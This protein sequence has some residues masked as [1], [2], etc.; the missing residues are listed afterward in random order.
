MTESDRRPK[1]LFLITKSNFGGAQRYVF[2]MARAMQEEYDVVV[3]FGGQGALKE[4]LEAAGIR[5]VEITGFQ[6]DVNPLKELRSWRELYRLYKTEQP[7]IV[8]L[9]SS[10]AGLSGALIGRIAGVRPI[11]FT[12]H[13]WPFLEPRAW[14]WRALTWLGAYATGLLAH[15]VIPISQYD[16]K[17]ARMPFMAKKYTDIIYNAVPSIDFLPHAAARHALVGAEVAA[18]HATDTWLITTAELHP[19]KN[20]ATAIRAVAAYNRAHP[21]RPIFYL[22]CGEGVLRD[23]LTRLIRRER[24]DAQIKLLGY[25]SDAR[26]HLTAANIFL[27]PSWQEGLPYALL[28]A[29]AAHLPVIASNVCGLPEVIQNRRNGLLIDPADPESII[30]ALEQLVYQ[31]D[32]AHTYASALHIDITTFYTLERMANQTKAVYANSVASLSE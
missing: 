20:L 25:V 8:H 27:L 13:G 21:K 22:I 16:R 31:P 24:A 19:K 14:W 6:R 29:G 28:E 5:T 30:T 2:E 15:R 18:A 23:E 12:V 10:K 17:H 32:T 1:L 11:I 3:G 7:D 4:N 9:N 26:A